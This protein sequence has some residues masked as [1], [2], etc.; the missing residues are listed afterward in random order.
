MDITLKAILWI[1]DQFDRIVDPLI[2]VG[3]IG[4]IKLSMAKSK[5]Y[6]TLCWPRFE[7]GGDCCW[8]RASGKDVDV[9]ALAESLCSCWSFL[10]KCGAGSR[11][12]QRAFLQ[13]STR[14]PLARV[15]N[16]FGRVF[17]SGHLLTFDLHLFVTFCEASI[18]LKSELF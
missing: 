15:P 2:T 18:S 14:R 1:R 17:N 5:N 10:K 13:T 9:M 12:L 6:L 11:G 16:H 3:A 8:Q 4:K 7:L